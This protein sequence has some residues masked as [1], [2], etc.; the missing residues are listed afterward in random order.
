MPL[1]FPQAMEPLPLH[2]AQD[3]VP[4]PPQAPQVVRISTV[5]IPRQAPQA[6]VPDPP[7]VRQGGGGGGGPALRMCTSQ[8]AK[9]RNVATVPNHV[10]NDRTPGL[11]STVMGP[12]RKIL[13]GIGGLRQ[14]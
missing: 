12:R 13:E 2:E 9:T 1:H 8:P 6:T 3:R 11:L 10:D 14:E 5:P 7:H 4:A